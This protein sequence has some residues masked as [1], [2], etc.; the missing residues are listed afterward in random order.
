MDLFEVKPADLLNAWRDAVRAAE[1]AE[2]LAEHA[3][4]AVAAA[5]VRAVA[6][7]ELATLARQAAEAAPRA[8]ERAELAAAEAKLLASRL[9]DEGM[10]AAQ[11]TVD[12]ANA[13]EAETR[14]AYHD[15]EA[16]KLRHTTVF[17]P[18]TCGVSDRVSAA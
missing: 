6:S 7:A 16:L 8:A 2:R 4:E 3:A 1:L 10:P 9:R 17:S 14:E 5:D 18:P 11:F 13:L 12:S 15:A